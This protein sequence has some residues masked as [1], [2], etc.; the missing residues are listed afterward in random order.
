MGITLV[1]KGCCLSA[2]AEEL[3]LIRPIGDYRQPRQYGHMRCSVAFHSSCSHNFHDHTSSQ[4]QIGPLAYQLWRTPALI[5]RARDEPV[6]VSLAHFLDR[7]FAG[8]A[9]SVFAMECV[10]S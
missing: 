10:A 7:V 8:A 2:S 4:K 1:V 9:G 5:P 6:N 3:T